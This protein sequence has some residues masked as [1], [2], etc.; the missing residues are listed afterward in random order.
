MTSTTQ[1]ANRALWLSSY[2]EPLSI[3][4]LPIPEAT[5]GTIVVRILA[6][7]IVP[8]AYLAHTGKLAAF[9]LPLPYVPNPNAVG[10][11]HAV[12][13]DSVRL[14][15]GDL[16]YVDATVRARDDPNVWRD[17]SL[18]QFQKLPLE[19]AYPLNEHWLL[20]ELGY[21]AP[22][23]QAIAYYSVAAGAVMEAADVRAGETVVV[24][25]SGG[26]F[27]GLA[28]EVALALGASV[29]A[30]GRSEAK[31][32][33]MRDTLAAGD[34]FKYVVM[35]GDDGAD[36][37][38]IIK[39]TPDGAGADVYNDWSPAEL[40]GPPYLAAAAQTLRR[41]GRVVLSGGTHGNLTIPYDLAML[42]DLKIVGK[43]MC[44]P[45]TLHRLIRMIER[46]ALRIGEE[47]GSRLKVFS[48]EEHHEAV[49]Y[50]RVNGGWRSYTAIAPN[51]A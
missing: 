29:V 26:T 41:N 51:E 19:N 14:Q 39:A 46:G 36:A 30:L 20:R 49:E 37:Q 42:K 12:G 16:V 18:Q 31:L 27:G 50:A 7:P 44:A 40:A 33:A 43:W 38:A 48:L 45:A 32:S 28:V 8:Y 2:D 6:A 25:P 22:L 1:T 5:T 4:E 9:R 10:R 15:P 21:P 3:K 35:T 34:R 13:P 47:S 23:L 11:V 17:G 24:G